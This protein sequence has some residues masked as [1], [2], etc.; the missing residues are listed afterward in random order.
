MAF[1]GQSWFGA[2]WFTGLTDGQME[3][4]ENILWN[5]RFPRI[6]AAALIGAALS[7]SGAAYQAMFVNPLMS[8]Q[9]L[10]VLF[11]ASFGAAVGMVLLKSWYAVQMAA[12]A[13]GLAA[14]GLAVIIAMVW[15]MNSTIMLVLG[16]VISGALF[17]SLLELVKYTADTYNQ[18][19]AITYWLMGSLSQPDRETAFRAA[20]PICLGIAVLISMGRHMNILSMGEEEARALGLNVTKIRMTVIL[21]ATVISAMTVVI[22]GSIQWVGLIIPHLTRMITGPN[23]ERLIPAAALIGAI[24]LIV[25]DDICRLLF[26]FELPIGIVTSLIGIPCFA[27]VLHNARK[28]WN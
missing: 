13:G 26:T 18:L 19:P 11:G 14:V 23:N 9:M 3:V 25:V 4:L 12:F 10:G 8:P 21:C 17:S 20:I 28:G 15:R 1:L 2:P 6:I 24:Y 16:G 27:L 7:V 5:I 22:A